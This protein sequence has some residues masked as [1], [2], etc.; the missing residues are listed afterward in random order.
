M[1]LGQPAAQ[2][3]ADRRIPAGGG[4]LSREELDA[5]T[6]SELV[7]R[8]TALK[9]LLAS[10]AAAA[11]ALRR[12]VDACWEAIRQ[13]GCLYHF[14]PKRYGG[15]EFDVDT[16]I[17]A[18]LPLS[19]GCASTGWVAA[20]CVEH[21]WMLSL[22]PQGAQDETFG[23][24]FP[25]VV[26][27]G[28][29]A[30]PGNAEPVEGG[31]RLSGRWKW[32]TGIMHS[33]WVIVA[34][35]LAL[36]GPPQVR[37]FALPAT[38]V[39]VLDT[40]FVDGMIATGSNDIACNDVFVPEHRSLDVTTMR[41]G[42]S[43]GARLHAHNPVYRVPMTPFLAVTAAISAIGAAR[44]ALAGFEERI[45]VRVMYGTTTRQDEKPAAHMR[46][47]ESAALTSAAELLIRDVGRRTVACVA[48][49]AEAS[50]DLRIELRT[51][52]ALA[53]DMARKAIRL[54]A[55]GAGSSS[56]L[57]SDPIQRAQRDINV[58]ASHIVY[59][60]DLAT[61]LLGRSRIGLAPNSPV[62]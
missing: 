14:V 6:P 29:T 22:F 1:N 53:V 5:L 39:E 28:V 54:L 57:L 37:M 31:F 41:T 47:G 15:L 49:G 40:W 12:P 44:S 13:T 62:V 35:K 9:P 19:E 61:E 46:L 59:D 45:G 42:T 38:E 30:P 34:G 25:Y 2:R 50:L 11:E 24:A 3:P 20:F 21:N 18:M 48:D 4:F 27:P 32:G 58:M 60:F 52:V 26:A 23:G 8:T 16:F 51:Q 55:D 7:R 10:H 43:P 33:D 36:D 17:D 56:H